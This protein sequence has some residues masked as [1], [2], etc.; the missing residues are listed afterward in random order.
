LTFAFTFTFT[1]LAVDVEVHRGARKCQ[2]TS[3]SRKQ[4]LSPIH[5]VFDCVH[6]TLDCTN[7]TGLNRHIIPTYEFTCTVLSELNNDDDDH[8]DHDE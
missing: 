3:R 6:H 7:W 5:H 8:D 4:T 1:L 2:H